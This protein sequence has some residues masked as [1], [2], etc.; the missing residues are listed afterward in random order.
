MGTR[1]EIDDVGGTVVLGE[2]GEKNEEEYWSRTVL[3]D[4]ISAD[5][6]DFRVDL[7]EDDERCIIGLSAYHV[8]NEE[9]KRA[10]HLHLKAHLDHRQ[11]QQ[12]HGYLG[13]LLQYE[14]KARN[15]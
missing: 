1:L 7:G 13:Y 9:T 10:F 12:L 11:L 15:D 8:E 4:N 6:I 5:E 14:I 3:L 2:R